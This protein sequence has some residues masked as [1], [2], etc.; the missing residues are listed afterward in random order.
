MS[1]KNASATEVVRSGVPSVA[2]G[3][4][5]FA[6]FAVSGGAGPTVFWP[7]SRS[8]RSENH[9][10]ESKLLIQFTTYH[11]AILLNIRCSAHP[12]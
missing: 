10:F 2:F 3:A 6:R 4:A 12:T 8:R 5:S 9:K 7:W 1:T 11:G